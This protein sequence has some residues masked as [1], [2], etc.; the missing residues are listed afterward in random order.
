M[1][2][3][4]NQRTQ[5]ETRF[6][7]KAN[8]SA[9]RKFTRARIA[10]GVVCGLAI[11]GFAGAAE[12]RA[13]TPAPRVAA[14]AF[15]V[16]SIKPSADI[17]AVASAGKMP[18]VGLK[19]DNQQVDIG[20]FTLQQLIMYAYKL[21]AYQVIGPDWIKSSHWDIAATLP[22]GANKDQ[23][24]EMMQAL[25]ADRFKL[26][27]HHDTK[28]MAVLALEVGK[29]GVKMVPSPPDPPAPET[30]KPDDK[31][32][33]VLDTGDGQ[34]RVKTTGRMGEG[35]TTQVSG[36]P[37]GNVKVSVDNGMMHMESSKM[38]MEI[39]T[40]QLTAFLGQP[41]IDKTELKGSYVAAID[42][43]MEDLQAMV[44]SLGMNFGGAGPAAPQA[45]ASPV[46]SASDPSGGSVYASIEK[47]GLKL[48][49][50]KLP[51]DIIVVD[52]LEKIPTE[53]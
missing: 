36:G 26:E 1:N 39:L 42:I 18:H 5:D 28:E 12:V 44:R 25:L 32:T 41:V 3:T 33:K 14:L 48:N 23:V 31:D 46:P 10:L 51:V 47:L 11:F 40:A 24:P 19:V 37:M 45:N 29:N 13:Q 20:Y 6:G 43:S 22:E 9:A 38:T 16:A 50:E 2:N 53:N 27:I 8:G 35:G 7:R 49:K 21:K 15:D 30:P 4:W 34:V 52:H 17:M